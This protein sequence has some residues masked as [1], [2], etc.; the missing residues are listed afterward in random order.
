MV[1]RDRE[2]KLCEMGE[3]DLAECVAREEGSDEVEII[4]PDAVLNGEIE[5]WVLEGGESFEFVD[6]AKMEFGVLEMLTQDQAKQD[7]CGRGVG[8]DG[9]G[10]PQLDLIFGSERFS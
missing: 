1:P 10:N 7:L 4:V 6:E 9:L 3:H 5:G 8:L 2:V